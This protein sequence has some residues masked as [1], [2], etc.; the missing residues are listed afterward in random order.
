MD[1]M[2]FRT[3]LYIYIY[4]E[5]L[6]HKSD[7]SNFCDFEISVLCDSLYVKVSFCIKMKTLL[8]YIKEIF[9]IKKNDMSS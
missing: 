8:F 3:K 1:I 2:R 6:E 9:T 7:M 4:I 5:G